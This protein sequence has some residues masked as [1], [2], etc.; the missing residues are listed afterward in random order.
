MAEPELLFRAVWAESRNTLAIGKIDDRTAK[1]RV[2]AVSTGAEGT[3]A[4]ALPVL[5]FVTLRY[6]R[7]VG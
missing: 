7:G 2:S 4:V 1:N 5:H 6:T 3:Y